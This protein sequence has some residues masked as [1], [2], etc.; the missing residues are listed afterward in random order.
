MDTPLITRPGEGLTFT[1]SPTDQMTFLCQGDAE[2]PDVM[3]ERLAPGDGPPLHSHPWAGW[4]VV[5]CGTVRFHV[6]GRTTDLEA[7]SFIYTPADAVHAFMAIGDEEAEIVQYQWPGGFAAVYAEIAAAFADG[8][9]DP[10]ALA[11]VADRHG[12]ALHGPPL[13]VLEAGA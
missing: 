10:A 8:E 9:P 11:V 7:G 6:D 13:A 3:V 1:T 5:I 4:D 2:M 12:F